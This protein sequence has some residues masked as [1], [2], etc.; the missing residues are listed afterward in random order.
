QMNKKTIIVDLPETWAEFPSEGSGR[1]YRPQYM[2]AGTM[3]VYLMP[4]TDHD[5]VLI[6]LSEQ[7]ESLGMPLGEQ[8]HCEITKGALG[9][10]A[11]MLRKIP[12]VGLVQ[13][14]LLKCEITIFALHEMGNLETIH[15]ELKQASEIIHNIHFE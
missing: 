9:A 7:T 6:A 12:G 8:I 3:R 14:W 1:I 4:P 10:V 2:D 5:N 13:F 15:S 11:T